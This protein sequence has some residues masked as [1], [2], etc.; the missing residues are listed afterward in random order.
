MSQAMRK[1]NSPI[2]DVVPS[3]V[4][5]KVA[6]FVLSC[7]PFVTAV[8]VQSVTAD[9]CRTEQQVDLFSPTSSVN[10]IP[11]K[12]PSATSRLQPISVKL[13]NPSSQAVPKPQSAV[14]LQSSV[15]VQSSVSMQSR[16][17]IS[18]R[19]SASRFVDNGPC[20]TRKLATMVVVPKS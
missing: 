1:F 15:K 2:V 3:E 14:K 18:K 7:G 11:A 20:S 16:R 5:R 9:K 13:S 17:F 12:I 4:Y 19:R 8:G 6:G 10:C